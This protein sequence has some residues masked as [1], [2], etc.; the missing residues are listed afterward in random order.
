MVTDTRVI[1]DGDACEDD[2]DDVHNDLS[3]Q[4]YE[5]DINGDWYFEESL[6]DDDHC[7]CV[8]IRSPQYNGCDRFS[9]LDWEALVAD[10]EL[11]P[12]ELTMSRDAEL[13]IRDGMLEQKP[14]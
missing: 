11:L 5:D 7:C 3:P 14:F 8:A 6:L 4:L 10:L 1:I 12:V 2:D 13:L 9:F